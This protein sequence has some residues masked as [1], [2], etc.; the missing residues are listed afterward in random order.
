VSASLRRRGA[1]AARRAA[2]GGKPRDEDQDED[3][4]EDD[5]DDDDE[6][7]G[8][9]ED[10]D[11]NDDILKYLQRVARDLNDALQLR[12]ETLDLER[13]RGELAARLGLLGD[14]PPPPATN[15]L[16]A[17]THRLAQTNKNQ[18]KLSQAKPSQ[19]K[20]SQA[21]PSQ[22]KPS[23]AKPLTN[24]QTNHAAVTRSPNLATQPNLDASH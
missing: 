2:V 15:T 18:P 7:D 19:A 14:L 9:D 12:A 13:V 16:S 1:R 24:E 11:D 22:A 8:D 3:E 20:L 5:E 4:D 17:A 23:Q 10:G 21:K 6:D